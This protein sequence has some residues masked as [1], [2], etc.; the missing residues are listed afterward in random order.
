MVKM[1]TSSN[2]HVYI[3]ALR[4]LGNIVSSDEMEL[5]TNVVKEGNVVEGLVKVLERLEKQ[6]NVRILLFSINSSREK[7]IK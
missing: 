2:K 5:I 1:I 4:I 7:S 6:D 3:P